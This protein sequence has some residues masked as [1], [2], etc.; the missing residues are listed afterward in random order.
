MMGLT[1]STNAC[2]FLK[3]CGEFP[4]SSLRMLDSSLATSC[5]CTPAGNSV[6]KGVSFLLI[7]GSP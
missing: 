3:S 2:V 7:F 4:T 5:Y 6:P 1:F